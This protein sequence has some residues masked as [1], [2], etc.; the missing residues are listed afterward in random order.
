[1]CMCHVGPQPV[2]EGKS[3][4]GSGL[5]FQRAGKGTGNIRN[6]GRRAGLLE[7]PSLPQPLPSKMH[8]EVDEGGEVKGAMS[9][10]EPEMVAN[11]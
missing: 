4:S 3:S 10:H 8:V 2:K 5:Q 11:S 7:G 9:Q 1:M 6:E